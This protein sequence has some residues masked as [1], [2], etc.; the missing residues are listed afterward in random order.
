MTPR[1]QQ[2][3]ERA[4]SKTQLSASRL[5]VMLKAPV[6]GRVKTRLAHEVGAVE[7]TRFARM[8]AGAVQARM[9][10]CPR[11]RTWLAV[12]PDIATAGR[13]W[14]GRVPRRAQGRGDLGQR[15]QRILQWPGAGPIVIVGS[16]IPAIAT[17]DI[18]AA[19]RMLGR[20]DVVFGPATDGGYWLVGL[21]RTPRIILGCFSGVRWSTSTALADTVANLAGQRIGFVSTLQD[22]DDAADLRRV[23]AW[24]GRRITPLYARS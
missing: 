6:M 16:D 17:A 4:Q 1:R 7:A 18:A 15:M 24:C 5:V 14:P 23:R 20:C 3:R 19:F 9:V 11:W 8:A 22:V 2:A 21:R 10:A 13:W 12:S